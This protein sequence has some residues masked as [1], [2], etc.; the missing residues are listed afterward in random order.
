MSVPPASLTNCKICWLISRHLGNGAGHQTYTWV[1]KSWAANCLP[2][3]QTPRSQFQYLSL[4]GEGYRCACLS[5]DCEKKSQQKSFF[6]KWSQHLARITHGLVPAL[7]Y[8]HDLVLSP[9][10]IGHNKWHYILACFLCLS[11]GHFPEHVSHSL[12]M[13]CRLASSGL[14][15]LYANYPAEGFHPAPVVSYKHLCF[16][17]VFFSC[18]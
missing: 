16:C 5:S 6:Y 10:Y 17:F 18:Y 1:V 4:V 7:M 9:G 13:E 14:R 15:N 12:R 8:A 3:A 11:H 2:S